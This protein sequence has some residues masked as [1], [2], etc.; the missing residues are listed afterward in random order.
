MVLSSTSIDSIASAGTSCLH[1]EVPPVNPLDRFVRLSA[2]FLAA[3]ISLVTLVEPDR[4]RFL[5]A[6]GLA[7]PW[8]TRAETPLSHSFC[9]HVVNSGKALIVDDARVHP[10]LFDNPSIVELGV[11]SYLGVPLRERGGTVIGSFCVID[12]VP[13]EWTPDDEALLE[14]LAQAVV[15]ELDSRRSY[16]ELELATTSY[17]ELLDTTT[18]LVCAADGNGV[19]TYVNSAWCQAFG[20]SAAEAI[21]LRAVDLVSSEHKGRFVETARQLLDGMQVETLEVVALG[22]GGRRVVCRGS[23]TTQ[24]VTTAAGESRCIGTR[25]VYRDVTN[26]RRLEAARA[27]L[28]ATLEATSD[29]VGIAAMDGTV[30]YINTSG[31]RLVGLA[32]N[33]NLA[34][35]S[36]NH[37]HPASTLQLLADEAFPTALREGLW[38]GNGELLHCDGT[39]IPVSIVM[40][41]HPSLSPEEPGFFSAIMRDQR[42]QV[43][44][45]AALSASESQL[46]AM[47]ANAA[48]GVTVVAADGTIVQTNAAFDRTLGYAAGSLVGR[49]APD[50]SPAEDAHITRD[51]VRSLRDG[52]LDGVCVEKRYWTADGQSRVLSLSLSLVP[53]ANGSDAV[54][55]L[56][57][58]VT[59]RVRA[60]E[61]LVSERAFLHATL[62]SLSDGVVACDA[63]GKLVLFNSATRILHGAV[64]QPL[65]P[66]HWAD[67]YDLYRADGS[68]PL[69][70]CEI[71]L[72]RSLQG[73]EV[74]NAEMVIA[75]RDELPR[76]VLASGKALRAADGSIQGAVVAMRDV[77]A[78]READLALRE[79]EDRYRRLLELLPDGVVK[80]VSGR[81]EFANAA[82]ARLVGVHDPAELVGQP[83]HTLL[84]VTDVEVA[85][86]RAEAALAASVNGVSI[87]EEQVRRCDGSAVACEIVGTRVD[88]RGVPGVLSVVRD[89]SERHRHEAALREREERLALVYNH[90]SDLMF[91]MR[92]ERDD[93]GAVAAYRCESVNEP[94]LATTGKPLEAFVG[95]LLQDIVDPAQLSAFRARY[96]DA[97]R[98]GQKQQYEVRATGAN[99][100]MVLETTLTPV[101]DAHGRCTHILGANRD[102]TARR[103]AEAGLQESEAAFR[104]MLQTVRAVA[105]TLDETGRVTFANE[106]LLALTG[107]QREEVT[108]ADWFQRFTVDAAGMRRLFDGM[109]AG[110]D[111]VPHY[112]SELLTRTKRRRLIVWD[113]TVLRDG[114]GRII[115]T[116]SI[117]QDVTDQRALEARL[118]ELSEHDELTGLLN[119]RGFVDRVEQGMHQARRSKRH[120]ALLYL[121]L[122]RFKPINDTY[123]HAAGDAA[124][125]AISDL[126][127]A[128][129][130]Q[131]DFAGRLGGDEFAIYATGLESAGDEALL[132]QRLQ[133]ALSKHNA[134]A[135]AAGRPYTLGFSVGVSVVR[136]DDKRDAL[137]AR[138]DAAL[139][140][141]KHA[142]RATDQRLEGGTTAG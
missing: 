46:R 54:L 66:E 109:M 103:I 138:A 35:I 130:R 133:T 70:V 118:A 61:Q 43:A 21:G 128:T 6:V 4:Q 111:F 60:E 44:A 131:T 36:A 33:L 11:V 119:R 34:L 75:P 30:D 126:L 129:I 25:A 74:R 94:L 93:K 85:V 78:E 19:I 41:A 17:R 113:N 24:H 50:L 84:H 116:A 112:E 16:L 9:Q 42:E 12:H 23:A 45:A 15:A 88:D 49:Y 20:F 81:I 125:R 137:F 87:R 63:A 3:P 39:V 14:D 55:G 142:R 121:D 26:E 62:E 56:T 117:G 7:E 18:E 132:E 89:V 65:G 37:F 102:V 122:D 83:V 57:T 106:A 77:T 1:A 28:V 79:S 82:M 58:D 114:D 76:T 67:T 97:V 136:S 2:R 53:D 68:T 71:P 98:T 99:G 80:H 69:P 10:V 13:R 47:F 100:P 51:A 105:V 135:T 22:A 120:D 29:F 38:R 115:G 91:L 73:E 48:V 127:K 72:F 101:R 64:H 139:Y 5:A 8:A 134:N 141:V 59:A 96:D 32:D 107:W 31:R 123:G 90:V 104:T 40:T 92:V 27:R 52:E 95:R 108:N 124:L 86:A 110:R 140:E